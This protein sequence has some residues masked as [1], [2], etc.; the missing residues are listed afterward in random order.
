ME[1]EQNLL[2]EWMASTT[3]MQVDAEAAQ[4]R[5]MQRRWHEQWELTA[6]ENADV[7]KKQADQL[8]QEN[9]L[10]KT[11]LT[12]YMTKGAEKAVPEEEEKLRKENE[13]LKTQLAELLA[14][15]TNAS[16]NTSPRRRIRQKAAKTS[17]PSRSSFYSSQHEGFP[18][19]DPF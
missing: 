19:Q 10:L 8:R 14:K 5:E 1:R 9:D 15:D 2:A 3:G 16:A 6:E 18:S 17:G 13:L 12:V 4:D 7:F 11:Q